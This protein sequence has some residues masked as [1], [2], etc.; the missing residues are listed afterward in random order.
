MPPSGWRSGCATG[1]PICPAVQRAV[2][3]LADGKVAQDYPLATQAVN[4]EH[5]IH[6]Q[7]VALWLLAGLLAVVGLLV[8][9]QLLARLSFLEA[10]EYGTLRALGMSRRMLLAVGIA[11]AT[12]IGAV[13]A[14]VGVLVAVA[15]SPLFP[16]GLAGVAEPHP[17]VDADGAV[18]GLG[19]LAALLVTAAC[20]AWPTWRA[21]GARSPRAAPGP[22]ALGR[23][24]QFA[25]LATAS[26][27]PV[28]ALIGVQLAL[29]PGAGRTAVPVRSTI[30]S[31]VVGVTA[32]TGALL[33][34]ASLGHLLATPRLYG[35]T[36]DAYVSSVTEGAM[37]PAVR[38]ADSDPSVAGSSLGDSGA[39]LY[40]GGVRAD[41][42][43][44]LPGR[45]G[46]LL[47]VPIQGHLPDGPGQI[48]L[49]ERTLAAVHS[50]VGAT[51]GV[52]LAGARPHRFRIVGAAVFPTLSDVLGLGQGAALTTPGPVPPAAT[53]RPGSATVHAAG[54]VPEAGERAGRSQCPGGQGSPGRPVRGAGPGYAYRPGQ[55][56]AGPG[57]AVP[58]RGGAEPAGAADHHPLAA[59]LGP[60]P[61]A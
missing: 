61:A 38:I 37:G 6:L 2:S 54:P 52:S 46:S 51:I 11:R 7:A 59:H 23:R 20:A 4:T 42:I 35:V 48:A 29:Q 40:V 44:M 14:A 3:R 33:F 47:P 12:A 43:A 19:A 55:F 30:A 18:L 22:A 16:V 27:R 45:D 39:P 26:V 36:W 28:T 25:A 34:S 53:R 57:P 24:P 60:P 17:G 56:R 49:G 58:A 13:G 21:T 8:L 5:S 31:A 1:R 10:T 9:G 15:A 50:R 41:A 32:L